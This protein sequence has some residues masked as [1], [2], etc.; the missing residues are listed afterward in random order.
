MGKMNKVRAGYGAIATSAK[1]AASG[2]VIRMLAAAINVNPRRVLARPQ[3]KVAELHT[4]TAAAR[5]LN[6][7]GS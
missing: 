5:A 7:E 3:C 1:L 6:E 2:E 4:R